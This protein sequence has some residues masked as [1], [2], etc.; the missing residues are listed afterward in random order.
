LV[1]RRQLTGAH[2]ASLRKMADCG[3]SSAETR[4]AQRRWLTCST[5]GVTLANNLAAAD[6]DT[7]EG[8]TGRWP[9]ACMAVN[10]TADPPVTSPMPRMSPHARS[11]A[12]SH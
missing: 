1:A 8:I 12:M 7:V 6:D 10:N 11:N 3:S 4:S 5:S 9:L 2:F